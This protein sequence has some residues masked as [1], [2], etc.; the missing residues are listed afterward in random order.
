[1]LIVINISKW[2][3]N[4][5]NNNLTKFGFNP[6]FEAEANMYENLYVGRVTSQAKHLYRIMTSQGE[7]LGEVSGKY[8]YETKDLADFPAAGDYVMIDRLDDNQGHAII[9]H[10]LTRQSA[11]V[12]SAAG[13]AH[14][15]QVVA[16]NMD[17]I[18]ITVALNNDFNV[19]R[20]ERYLSSAWNSGATPVIVLTK[21]DL[22]QTL[23]EQLMDVE[24]VA[25]GV[26]I[27]LSSPDDDSGIKQI[28]QLLMPN[29]TGVFVGSSGVGKS[30]LINRLLGESVLTTQGLRNDDRGR[31]TTTYRQLFTL[32]GGGVVI[33]TPGMRQL[34]VENTDISKGFA[35][36]D[37][38]ATQCKFNDCSHTNEPQCAVQAAIQNGSLSQERYD[39]YLK[40]KKE[41]AYEGL[42]SREI[43]HVKLDEMFKE[44]GGMKGA[45]KQLK[46]KAR[47]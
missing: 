29:K 1:M 13:T 8:R 5:N 33:D 25:L 16:A 9:H 18:F 2:R 46:H 30:T 38:L 26:D 19:R 24:D 45:R 27:I 23:T 21:T 28:H 4:V 3:N 11:M 31:H 36:I 17:Y 20:L 32:P 14:E 35:D 37:E 6:R 39:S 40:L 22:S 12:R 47:K 41:S 44:V 43:E 10:T 42:S 34:S 15:S 7:L